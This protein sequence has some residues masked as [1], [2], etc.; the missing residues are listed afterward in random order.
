MYA[1]S[2][3]AKRTERERFFHAE[4][5]VL[6]SEYTNPILTGGDFICTLQPVDSTGPFTTS[7]ALAEIVRGIRLTDVWNQD[8][9]HPT[10]THYSATGASRIDRIYL[11]RADK[12][13]KTGI[14]I[15]PT[16]F[17]NYHAVVLRLSIQAPEKRR[18]RGRGKWTLTSY[19]SLRS[20]QSFRLNER[21]GEATI[22]TTPTWECSG[23]AM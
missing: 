22:G 20:R 2:G 14:E 6:F 16:A 8:P 3:T 13:R 19:K 23:S 1:P 12:D 17:T 7:N 10:Y 4:L 21:N 18:R 9:R 15:I 11:S 5:S